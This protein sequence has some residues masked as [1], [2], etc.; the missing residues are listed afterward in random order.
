MLTPFPPLPLVT[1]SVS[2]KIV[3]PRKLVSLPGLSE[4]NTSVPSMSMFGG[5]G[6]G[7]CP[8]TRSSAPVEVT[9]IDAD[10]RRGELGFGE[11]SADCRFRSCNRASF[12]P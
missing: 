9:E 11:I 3:R 4:P 8:G 10:L 5:T 7:V 12:L 6:G 2:S 1:Y